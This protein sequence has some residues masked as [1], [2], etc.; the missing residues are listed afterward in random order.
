MTPFVITGGIDTDIVCNKTLHLTLEDKY[1]W[2]SV[3]EKQFMYY[4]LFQAILT[5]LTLPITFGELQYYYCLRSLTIAKS[6]SR[7]KLAISYFVYNYY[8]ILYHHSII[9]IHHY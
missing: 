8:S 7:S 6:L 5:S 4:F 1:Q 9:I 2:L 3:T